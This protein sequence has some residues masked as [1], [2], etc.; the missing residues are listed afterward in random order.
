MSDAMAAVGVEDARFPL[1]DEARVAY[2]AQPAGAAPFFGVV[3]IHEIYGLNENIRA[4]AQRFAEAGY[5][6]LAV[7]LF[8]GRN[9][10]FCMFRIFSPGDRGVAQQ[11]HI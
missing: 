5:A 6:A 1:R 8:A 11:H 7:D 10:T 3:V 4:V 9:R 2:I